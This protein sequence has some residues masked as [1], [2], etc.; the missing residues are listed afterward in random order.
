LEKKTFS[1]FAHL[2]AGGDNHLAQVDQSLL[3][4]GRHRALRPVKKKRNAFARIGAAWL[5]FLSGFDV[6]LIGIEMVGEGAFPAEGMYTCKAKTCWI[7]EPNSSLE[8]YSGVEFGG[9][10]VHIP[11]SAT[12]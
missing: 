9:S 3:A 5:G 8:Y 10:A 11:L 1:I 7:D 6:I 4:G 2:S 12:T